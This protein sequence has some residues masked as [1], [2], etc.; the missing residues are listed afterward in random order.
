MPLQKPDLLH[1]LQVEARALLQPLRLDQ[2]AVA[3]RSSS[4]RS[5]SSALIV[6]IA[7]ISV[8]ARRHVVRSRIDREARD[9]LADLGR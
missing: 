4:S 7:C 9:L 8:V 3:D 5:R 1:H 2:L 6:S